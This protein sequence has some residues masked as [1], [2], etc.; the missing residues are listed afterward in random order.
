MHE[1]DAKRYTVDVCTGADRSHVVVVVRGSVYH[2]VP[3]ARR[4]ESTN[5]AHVRRGDLK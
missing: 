2:V 3:L 5:V 1:D 4:S